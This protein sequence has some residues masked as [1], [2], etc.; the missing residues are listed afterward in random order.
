MMNSMERILAVCN[1]ELPDR[2]PF[3]L[4]TRE[5]GMKYAGF[6]LSNAFT[7]PDSFIRAQIKVMQDFNQDGV[8]DINAV[9]VVDEAL[10]AKL[11]FPEDDSPYVD[12]NP[13]LKSIA[14]LDKLKP[15]NPNTDGRMPYMLSLVQKLK[16]AVGPNVPLFAWVSQP[17]RSACMLRGETN[18]YRDLIRHPNEA[19]ELLSFLTDNLIA[20]GKALIDRG[21]DIIHTS[22][23]VAN[24]ECISLKHYREFVHPY[25]KRFLGSLKEYG[26][27]K[28]MYH[29]CG[30]WSDRLD[31]VCEEN[32][33]IIHFDEI[34]ISEFKQRFSDKAVAFG[35]LHT[36]DVLHQGTP[37]TA[38]EAA[39]QCIKDGKAGGRFILS[40]NCS[41]PRDTPPENI[42]A[43]C[44]VHEKFGR[45]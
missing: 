26:A 10:G 13:F 34:A 36:V 30:R 15:V 22:N 17:F 7:D 21:A 16:A 19:K 31:L 2:I 8:W 14:E 6:S 25:S 42:R 43:I 45:Y 12:Y 23:P 33:D 37:E 41:V 9:P 3:L 29:T 18:F 44:R 4:S 38:A 28:T 20:Y 27:K 1:H 11:I 35:N 5:F 40:A 39:L 32:A 24:T